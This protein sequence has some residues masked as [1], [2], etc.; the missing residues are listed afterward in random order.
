[1]I[2]PAIDLIGGKV[3]R[4][5]QGDYGRRTD[6]GV[7]PRERFALYAAEGARYLHLVDLDGAKD[8]AAR[9]LAVI[10]DLLRDAPA[11]VEV[12]GGVRTEKDIEDLLGAGADRVVVGSACVGNRPAAKAWLRRFGPDRLAFALDVN[13]AADGRRLVA[14]KGWRESSALTAEELIEDYA[15]E[16]LRYVLCTDISRDGTLLGPNAELYADLSRRFPGIAFL[17]SGGVGSLADVAAVRASGAAGI[18]VGRSLLEGR[19]T[20]KEAVRCWPNE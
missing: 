1:M 16:G 13:I 6:Y 9:Q 11:P 18:V 12:G 20:V 2:I 4:L 15:A 19:F 7:S 8:P 14:V 17:A 3:V 5:R 10:A